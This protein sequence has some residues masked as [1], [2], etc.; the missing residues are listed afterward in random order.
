MW[1][2][3]AYSLRE[4]LGQTGFIGVGRR[5]AI[6]S[7]IPGWQTYHLDTEPNGAVYKPDSLYME[8]VKP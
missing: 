6:E 1:M 7:R 3:D 8:G 2:Y 4:L 5:T